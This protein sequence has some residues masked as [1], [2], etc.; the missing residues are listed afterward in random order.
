MSAIIDI[1]LPAADII[2]R[3]RFIVY[4]PGHISPDITIALVNLMPV[5]PDTELDFLRL[6]APAEAN[7]EVRLIDMSTHRSRHTSAEHL[8]RFYRPFSDQPSM[9]DGVI[10]TGAPLEN[11]AFEHVDYWQELTEI[12]DILHRHRIPTLYI[13]WAAYAVLYHRYGLTM[14]LLHKKLSGVYPHEITDHTSPLLQGIKAPFHIPH[15]RFATWNPTEIARISDLR[16]AATGTAQGP[17][18]I[19]S[20][21]HPEHYITG[22]GEY[23]TMTLDNEY[24]RDMAKGMNPQIPIN[25][26]PDD[27]PEATPVNR[28]HHTAIK[29]MANWLNQVT[30]I[31]ISRN[32]TI[33]T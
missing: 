26:Y 10:I 4:P 22:H 27:N 16:T 30:N 19:S 13:C 31:K 32:K 24:R 11:I 6:I 1:G 2:R 17:Y 20:R 18:L 8:Q 21:S 15:S 28:W 7:I 25:Y 9:P 23:A 12:F 33:T 5:K 14:H 3:E 29:I